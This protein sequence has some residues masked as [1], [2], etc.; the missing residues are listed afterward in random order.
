MKKNI[1]YINQVI[2]ETRKKKGL[3]QVQFA[4]MINKSTGTVKRYDTGDIIPENTLRVICNLL[5][6]DFIDLLEMDYILNSP[7]IDDYKEII[8]KYIIYEETEEEKKLFLEEER[9][10][11]E[12]KENRLIEEVLYLFENYYNVYFHYENTKD[13]EFPRR[14]VFVKF[15]YK[16]MKDNRVKFYYEFDDLSKYEIEFKSNT[17][18]IFTIEEI[19]NLKER[20]EE[21]FNL[22]LILLNLKKKKTL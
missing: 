15:R 12:L 21:Y 7:K 16:K 13:V 11:E 20:I 19:K 5:N 6:I 8:E 9:K 18:G 17:I 22:E 14:T 10:I 3:T 2:K 1:P 4:K